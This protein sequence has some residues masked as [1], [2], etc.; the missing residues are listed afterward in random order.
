MNK[1]LFHIFFVSFL[2]LMPSILRGSHIVGGAISYKFVKRQ[3]NKIQ[4]HFTMK[5]YMD[6]VTRRP[7]A[8]FDDPAYIGI[9]LNSGNGYELF[10]NANDKQPIIQRIDFRKQIIPNEIPCLTPPS[11]IKIDEAIYEWDAVLFDTSFS[12]IVSYQKCCRNGTIRNIYSPGVTGSTYS[13]EITPDAQH[14]DNS[15]PVFKTFPPVFVCVGERVNYDHSAEDSENDQLVYS[16]CTAF[17]SPQR[18]NQNNL[19]PPPPPY[20]AIAYVQPDYTD[21]RPV[22][23]DPIVTIDPNTGLIDGIPNTIGQYVVTVCVAEYRGGKLMSRMFR[24]FQFNVVQCQKSVDALISADSTFGKKF[25]LKGCENISLTIQNKS[26]ERKQIKDFYWEFDMKKNGIVRSTDWD[27]SVV[28]QDTGLFVGKLVLNSGSQ[29]SDSAFFKVQIGGRIT[30]NFTTRYDTCIAGPVEF[31]G[32]FTSAYPVREIKWNY[33]DD[34][35]EYGKTNTSLQYEKPGVK[36]VVFSIIDEFGC[37]GATIKD[38][39]WQPAPNFIIVEPDNYIGCAPARVFFKNRSFPIDSTYNIRWEFG[40]GN[41][42]KDISP[43]NTY[44]KGGTYSVKLTIISPLGCKKEAFYSQWIKIKNSPEADFEYAPERVTSLNP[45]VGFTDLSKRGLAW[46]W[47]FNPG[48]SS[49]QNPI[50]TFRDTGFFNVKL[51]VRNNEGCVDSITKR[52]YVEP[53]VTFNMPNAFTPN[54]DGINEGFKGTGILFGMK[55][56]QMSIFNRWGE[57]IFKTEDPTKA[58][59]GSKDNAGD[60]SPQGVYLYVVSYVTPTNQPVEL[61]GYATLIR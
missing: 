44:A 9:Y 12:Y 2:V 3:G 40:D 56:F 42:G 52:I 38:V 48:F 49:R 45:V 13:I 46:Q 47:F 60:P 5:M 55:Q 18:G 35:T 22:G 23:G 51:A 31:K 58:W 34:K 1:H 28:Y 10:G 26:Y 61:K 19:V 37:K 25:F 11:N 43:Y 57:R 14:N 36:K 33:D 27:P 21:S 41:I 50:H 8:D 17:S 15:S 20:S 53:I 29:C 32:V 59:N 6:L 16:F 7:N 30:S 24:D 4:Y 54:D 39:P